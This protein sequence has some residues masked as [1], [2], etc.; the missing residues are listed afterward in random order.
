[1]YFNYRLLGVINE[2]LARFLSTRDLLVFI[3]EGLPGLVNK[4]LAGFY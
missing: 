1:M 3:K 2:G 4:G